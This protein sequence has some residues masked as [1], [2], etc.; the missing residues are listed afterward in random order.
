MILY[1]A[2]YFNFYIAVNRHSWKIFPFKL[3]IGTPFWRIRLE[4]FLNIELEKL[5]RS[6]EFYIYRQLCTNALYPQDT[7]GE[8]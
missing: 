6:T 7:V 5:A 1:L 4:I 8:E 3:I 2:F